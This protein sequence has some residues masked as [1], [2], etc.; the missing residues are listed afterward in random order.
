MSTM[1]EVMVPTG[2]TATATPNRRRP[3]AAAVARRGLRFI[4][5]LAL[6]DDPAFTELGTEVSTRLQHAID[7][8]NDASRERSASLRGED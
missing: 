1:G 2:L 7:A 3:T 4:D 8:L 6:M 5:P